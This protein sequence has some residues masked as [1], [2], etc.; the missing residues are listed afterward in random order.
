MS[1]HHFLLLLPRTYESFVA[2][3]NAI[4]SA[5]SFGKQR[6]KETLLLLYK[7]LLYKINKN[8]FQVSAVLLSVFF[9]YHQDS[10]KNYVGIFEYFL[11]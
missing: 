10:K 3:E 9:L 1:L 11:N 5:K 8:T 2:K 7:N 6:N 4:G